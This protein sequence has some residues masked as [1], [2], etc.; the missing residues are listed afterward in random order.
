[1]NR[2]AESMKFKQRAVQRAQETVEL[3]EA[4]EESLKLQCH[5][6]KLLNQYDGGER[7]TFENADAWMARLR[8]ISP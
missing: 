1:M 2:D 8:E 3:R 5:Y 6:A 4:L 7:L